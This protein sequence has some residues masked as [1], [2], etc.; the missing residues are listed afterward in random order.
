MFTFNWNEF[1]ELE[2]N[3]LLSEQTITKPIITIV[4]TSICYFLHIQPL[5]RIWYKHNVIYALV[6]FACD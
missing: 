3:K 4:I 2:K 5:I 1:E 6:W